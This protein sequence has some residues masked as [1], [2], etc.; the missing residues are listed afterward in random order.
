MQTSTVT[1]D[2]ADLVFDYEGSGP[3]LLTIAA[4]GGTGERYAGVSGILKTDFTVVRYDRRCCG[5]SSGDRSRPMD[6]LQQARD[7]LA[8]L[9]AAGA[10][11]AY[12]LGNS[13]GSAIALKIAEHF[14]EV[15]LGMIVHEPVSIC[16]LDDRDDMMK[17]NR[18]VD[19]V[20]HREGAGPAGKLLA[21]NMVG[22]ASSGPP[23]QSDDAEF[24]LAN[25]HMSLCY[26]WPDLDRIKR[27][28]VNLVASKGKLSDGAFYARSADAI[29]REVGCPVYELSGN[30]IAYTTD[31][32]TFAAELRPILAGLEGR[33][34]A[35]PAAG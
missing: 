34:A 5:R 31:P 26:Y 30:H 19:D 28:G 35:A 29:A 18:S 22:M 10:S 17:F 2:G 7:A 21:S 33:H 13:A 20:Y 14:P 11:Q 32:A 12:I 3:V 1:T 24:F 23:R 8:V 16:V 25:E 15:V 9:S 4:R 6:M 27:N